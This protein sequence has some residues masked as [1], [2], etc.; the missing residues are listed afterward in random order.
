MSKNMIRLFLLAAASLC[1]LCGCVKR[2]SGSGGTAGLYTQQEETPVEATNTDGRKETAGLVIVVAKDEENSQITVQEVG[3]QEL[4]ALNYTAG[5]SI[6][7]RYGTEILMKDLELG[8]IA[9]ITYVPGTQKLLSIRESEQAWENTTVSKWSVD[10]EKQIM[11]IG[12]DKY[13]FDGTLVILSDGRRIDIHELNQ[14]DTLIVKGIDKKLC[15]IQVKVGHGYVRVTDETALVGGL[16]EIGTKIMT[17]ISEDMIIVAP[18]GTYTLTASKDGVGGSKEIMVTRNDE[19]LVSLKEFQGEVER[20]GNVKFNIQPEGVEYNIFIDGE[21]VDATQAVPL[22][23]GV[24]KVVITSN[25]YTDYTEEIVINRIYMNKTIDLSGEN[26]TE[27]VETE[28]EAETTKEALTEDE[29]EE[30]SDSEEET[31]SEVETRQTA[32]RNNEVTVRGPEGAEVYLDGLYI[33]T[34]PLTF[35]KTAGNHIFVLRQDGY[36]TRAY[37]YTFDDTENDIYIKFPDMEETQS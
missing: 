33:G 30:T 35:T 9:E 31:S 4:F 23:Y 36:E 11:T 19:T 18:E 32:S 12:S 29:T 21:A 1:L 25:K 27:E 22:S 7:N 24:H 26:S 8:E 5:T 2:S 34:A 3:T 13:S 6:Q 16:I 20:Q 15:S 17:V 14:V 10:Y 28:T 37:S